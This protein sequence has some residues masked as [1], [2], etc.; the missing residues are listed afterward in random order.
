MHGSNGQGAKGTNAEA[1]QVPKGRQL[2]DYMYVSISWVQPIILFFFLRWGGDSG[3]AISVLLLQIDDGVPVEQQGG[4][5][6]GHQGQTNAHV[7]H[8]CV[9]H[10]QSFK[11]RR[12]ASLSRNIDEIDKSGKCAPA[13]EVYFKENI[14]E[15]L[16]LHKKTK[17]MKIIFFL[18]NQ[19]KKVKIMREPTIEIC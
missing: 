14:W 11:E 3:E 10:L 7:E 18:N 13:G 19:K 5:E 12:I 15:N 2:V 1:K 4:E 17:K 8:V 9:Q 6:N 16:V